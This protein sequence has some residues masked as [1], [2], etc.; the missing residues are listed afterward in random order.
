MKN[1]EENLRSGFDN[2]TWFVHT[3]GTKVNIPV[4]NFAKSALPLQ[5]CYI[6]GITVKQDDLGQKGTAPYV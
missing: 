4:V 3:D 5:E 2:L 1:P 6:G